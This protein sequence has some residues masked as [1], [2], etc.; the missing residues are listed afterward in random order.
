MKGIYR[1]ILCIGILIVNSCHYSYSQKKD[2]VY[3]KNPY[4]RNNVINSNQKTT[5]DKVFKNAIDLTKYL[6]TG[7]VE[8]ATIDYTTYLQKGLNE[9]SIVKIPNFP[10]LVNENG[11][12]LRSG[13]RIQFQKYSSLKIMP[14]SLT[15]YGILRLFNVND[16]IINSPVIVGERNEHIG[17]KGEWGMGLEILSSKNIQIFNPNVSGCW[18]DGIY[19]G[20]LKDGSS[21]NIK[22]IGGVIDNCRRNGISI[23]DGVN[24]EIRNIIIS[25]TQG[26]PPMSGIDI[27]PNNNKENADSIFILNPITFN[28]NNAGIEIDLNMNNGNVKNNFRIVNN[29]IRI[30]NHMDDNSDIGLLFDRYRENSDIKTISLGTIEIIN[31]AFLNNRN[32]IFFGDNNFKRGPMISLKNIK[33]NNQKDNLKMIKSEF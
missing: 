17:T 1:L 13:S 28:N 23:T 33:I 11:L 29:N 22:I 8:D 25:N 14:N 9:N 6:P 19:I 21:K 15:Y 2:F 4:L 18:G 16:I 32:A 5:E 7:F 24:I 10:L 26:T 31:S 12:N 27:E 3:K 30:E 20:G